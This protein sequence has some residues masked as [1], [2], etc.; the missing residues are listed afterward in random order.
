MTGFDAYEAA[1]SMYEVHKFMALDT[2]EVTYFIQQVG[3]AAASFGVAK[4]DITAVATTLG[5]VFNVKCGPA[6]TLIKAQGEQ[7]QS[8][9]IAE[10]CAEA[11]MAT[12]DAYE[13]VIEPEMVKPNTTA[14]TTAAPTASATQTMAP[15]DVPTDAAVANGLSFAAIAVGI[16]AFAL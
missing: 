1:A 6:T 9:C 10:D 3:A 16:A 13:K 5:D 11:K 15:S 14:T 4:D 12:C 2:A 8:I 7:L